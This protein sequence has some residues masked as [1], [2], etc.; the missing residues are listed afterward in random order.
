MRKRSITCQFSPNDASPNLEDSNVEVLANTVQMQMFTMRELL[1]QEILKL[2]QNATIEELSSI[3]PNSTSMLVFVLHLSACYP[4]RK[5]PNWNDN[6]P[7]QVFSR[8]S[9]QW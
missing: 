2:N 3:A 7:F 4:T 8:I 1:H 9:L 6:N 5:L